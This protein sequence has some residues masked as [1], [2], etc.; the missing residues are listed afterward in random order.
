MYISKLQTNMA[1]FVNSNS[2]IQ[3][4]DTLEIW[5]E[6]YLVIVDVP[7]KDKAITHDDLSV[8]NLKYVL[9]FIS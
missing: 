9:L 6:N 7:C 8:S 3:F 4:Y 5:W 1:I 2:L